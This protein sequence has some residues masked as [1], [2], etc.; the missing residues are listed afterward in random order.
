MTHRPPRLQEII[1]EYEEWKRPSL[2]GLEALNVPVL[3]LYEFPGLQSLQGLGDR[4]KVLTICGLSNLIDYRP[5]R[6]VELD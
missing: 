3:A 4:V 5:V 1:I 6:D 2:I